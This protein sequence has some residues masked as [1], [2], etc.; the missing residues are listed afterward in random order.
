M[1]NP[2]KKFGEE[3]GLLDKLYGYSIP[4][5]LAKTLG[6]EQEFKRIVAGSLLTV[7][8]E[9]LELSRMITKPSLETIE[10]QEESFEDYLGYMVGSENVTMTQ[11]GEEE[12]GG[13]ATAN[14]T[15]PES[16]PGQLARMGGGIVAGVFGA[17]KFAAP[18]KYGMKKLG[19]GASIPAATTKLGRAASY[20]A[21]QASAGA[22]GSQ[23]GFNPYE[24]QLGEMIAGSLSE[25]DGYYEEIR[26]YLLADRQTKTQLQN[27]IDL[28]GEGIFIGT[29]M[30]A[31]GG[32]FKGGKY[33][34]ET[35]AS[36][37]FVTAF[38]NELDK[39]SALG[40]EGI[41][42]FMSKLDYKN[43]D[44]AQLKATLE[45]RQKDVIDGKLVDMGDIEAIKPSKY[46][47]WIS[48]INLQFSSSPILRKL[49]N[50]RTKLT[51]TKGGRGRK[52]NE[53]YLKTENIKE[54]WTDNINNI[55]YNLEASL[56]DL[57]KKVSDGKW[58]GSNRKENKDIFLQK[59][60]DVLYTDFRT[61]TIV[62]S[63]R[64]ISVGKRQKPT[65]EKELQKNFPKEMWDD[66][67]TARR[68]QDDLSE[69]ML[70]TGSL[71]NA[72]TKIYTD[73]LGFY[74][75]K[76]YKLYEDTGYVPTK[77][78]KN[79]ARIYLREQ[80]QK[81][82]PTLSEAQLFTDVETELN[83]ILDVNRTSDSFR[84]NLDSFDK[85][86]K[87]IL[88]GRKVIPKPIANLLGEIEDPIQSLIF[89]AT[90]L[91]KF[92]E[93]T[94]FYD[95][96][97][98]D[99]SEI[100]FKSK[101]S[102]AFTEE[103]GEGY[104][105]LSK[106]Y[107]TPEMKEYFSNH[108]KFGEELLQN[109]EFSI[110]GGVGWAYRTTLLLK[111]LSQAAKTVYSH[112]THFKNVIG[113]NHMSLA[114]GVNTLSPTKGWNIIKVLRAKTRRDKDA[115]EYHEE[116]SGRGLLNKGTVTRDLQ[117]LAKD[118]AKVQK[119]F[120]IGK[121]DWAFDKAGLKKVARGAQNFYVGTDDFYKIN[122][123][124]SEQIW[125]NDFQKALP[126]GNQFNK[127]RQTAEELK[128]ESALIVRTTLP[129]YDMVPE[130]L[131]DLRRVPFVG[132]FFS[133]M[134]ESV[135]ISQGSLMRS[136][137]EINTG[138]QLIKE[139]ADDA[140][141]II[142]NRGTLRLAAFTTMAGVGG[143]AM[144]VGTKAAYGVTT[145]VVDAMRDMLPDYMQNA[146]L[147][148]TVKE[149]G[150][151][152]VANISSWDAYDFPKKPFQVISNKILNTNNLNED[153]LSKDILTTLVNEMATPFIGESL[154]QEQLSNYFLSDGMTDEKRLMRNPFN[155]VE[156]YD[157][158]G[159]KLENRFNQKNLN[160]LMANLFKTVL[161]GS[162]D[163]GI[164]WVKTLNKDQTNFDQDIYPVD[165]AIKFLT[166]WGVQPFNKEYVENVFTFKAREYNKDK[167]F[168]RNRLYNA[169]TPDFDSDVFINNYL[170]ENREYAKSYAKAS[171]L[172]KSGK[173][174]K[175]DINKLLKDSGY[176]SKDRISLLHSS[177]YKPLGL[178]K[179]MK[180]RIKETAGPSVYE[181]LKQDINSIDG[182]LSNI[183]ILYDPENYKATAAETFKE[184]RDEYKTG[185]LVP[186]VEEN[187]EDRINP[188]TGQ[189]YE[190]TRLGF[191]Q[192]G[193]SEIISL[194]GEGSFN[195]EMPSI[196]EY[197]SE[198]QKLETLISNSKLVSKE[199]QMS[200]LSGRGY[201]DPRFIKTTGV[202]AIDKFGL[203]PFPP[204]GSGQ[205]LSTKQIGIKGQ[206]SIPD[207]KAG[208]YNPSTD[209]VKYKDVSE[210]IDKNTESTQVHELFH[211]SAE[212][213]GWLD[214]F[215]KDE[216]L[217]LKAPKV[218]GSRGKQ[219]R[220]V[221]NEAVAE[222]YEHT[223]AGG[224]LNDD[225]LKKEIFNRV[226][227]FNIKYPDKI[228]KD[229][230]KSLPELR[231]SF[232]KYTEEVKINK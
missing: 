221:I 48:D 56:D 217:N 227:K 18:I 2:D 139:G 161:P 118:N 176:S 43:T 163:R 44:A 111:G 6:K 198:I 142:R 200:S 119:G 155:R 38:R 39:V 27:R 90:K 131:K 84:V 162:I 169:I 164:D 93:D 168:R 83:R 95:E 57:V 103:I 157:N 147:F 158:S 230:M 172:L 8:R 196:V 134:S 33:L 153:V 79:E 214:T 26:Q 210:H 149:D 72:Q 189:T 29:G 160:I 222:S 50:F 109:N 207:L 96:A 30:A 106:T 137:K 88:N 22:V 99:G 102:G 28:L 126:T 183:K 59:L 205:V 171:K 80:I 101:P 108:Q 77:D 46:T 42:N 37:K 194:E 232:E 206:D 107:T 179:A 112:A 21:K 89:S 150:T 74:V 211:R 114:N 91:S 185:G 82:T 61:P 12:A 3:T 23:I 113:G 115:Q 1:F 76:S 51:T 41:E 130:I 224:K 213:S 17:N 16:T 143:K 9:V 20:T 175:I 201:K 124:E 180:E 7:P 187:P 182:E 71:T 129:N 24:E 125:L 116:L 197:K 219:L 229:I 31:V 154:I 87:Q 156:Q 123:Y 195:K 69:L 122:M 35:E 65:F 19:L 146:N 92:V 188:V 52:L 45:Y 177:K 133:F 193:A 64:G 140:G 138:K 141:K 78:V 98:E 73:S 174:F 203:M 63:K 97:F 184:L 110:K 81:E 62:G 66:I 32:M 60:S 151:P 145:D 148:I 173:T 15:Q 212:K 170:D 53:K 132:T 218:S 25:G 178:T 165:Q 105:K 4:G 135:R 5:K 86:K 223:S 121:L 49:E 104:G 127:Y 136:F 58:F 128:D 67:R 70:E 220:N 199:A 47:K 144:E 117:G 181:K 85:I 152:A 192:G 75:R 13:Y 186:N 167:G 216:T 228:T 204:E 159:S 120:I 209:I 166:G 34:K 11:R 226:S 55:A 202:E 40:K 10:K 215:Y 14:I 231:K 54:K 100:Y 94:K 68:L 191:N 208:T 190:E 36:E 225:F